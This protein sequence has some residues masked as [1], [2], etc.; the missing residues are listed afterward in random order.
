MSD[1][2]AA[3]V[4][5][6]LPLVLATLSE[7]V[8]ERGGVVNLALEGMMLAGAFSAWLVAAGGGAG[9]LAP[10]LLVAALVG[11]ALAAIEALFV[12]ALRAN[13]I[14]VGSALHFLCV[15]ATGLLFERCKTSAGVTTFTQAGGA[16]ASAPYVGTLLLCVLVL[17]LLRQTRLGLAIRAAGDAPAALRAA[18]GSPARARTVA[19]LIAG[20]IAGL[21]G[22]TL[23]TTLTGSFGEGMTNGRGFLALGLV[24]FARWNALGALLAGLFLGGAFVLEMR[25]SL[26]GSN[27][28]L[29]SLPYLLT[30][31]ALALFG[32]RDSAAPAALGKPHDAE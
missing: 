17:V 25:F 7:V 20:A 9:M 14:V 4:R 32:T 30:I 3:I 13:S 19:L 23:T 15:G 8:A 22:A 26:G 11:G 31:G 1:E 16:W 24:L 10:A 5:I 27:F 21:A 6:A 2:A 28:L 29:R 18:G 12:V